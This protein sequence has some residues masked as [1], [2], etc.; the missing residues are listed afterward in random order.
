MPK[1]PKAPLSALFAINKPTGTPSMT[2][3]NRLQPL[4]AASAI[5]RD[6]DADA[7][8]DKGNQRGGGRR[9]RGRRGAPKVKMGQGGTLDP[10]ADGVLV[11]GTNAA[12]KHLSRFLDCTKEYRAI[13]LLGCS[14]DSYDSEGKRVRTVPGA[15]ALSRADVEAVLDRFRGEIVQTPPIFSALKMDGKPLYEYARTNT[16][17][18]RPI[19]P[20]TVTVHSLELLRFVPGDEHAYEY[21]AE[22]LDEAAKSELERLEKMV[23]EGRTEVPSEEEVAAASSAPAE[24]APTAESAPAASASTSTATSTS[25]SASPAPAP[26]RAP[27][28]EIRLTVS[29]GTYIRSIVHDIGAALGS[30]AHVVKLTRTRQGEFA[31][32]PPP[33][34]GVDEEGEGEGK[35]GAGCIEWALLERAIAAQERASK[36][37]K[38]GAAAGEGGPDA[39]AEG[40]RDADGWLE[41]ERELLAK[42]KE[43]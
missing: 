36:K 2:L 43:V 40:E 39:A 38:E 18:P 26:A 21:P 8:K 10:L 42:C 29:S 5:F 20:R 3:L 25:S 30:A 11:V 9:G 27:I 15:H 41:W 1:A 4:F 33:P 19:P 32:E 16:P 17:L 24:P 12:T 31:L 14:T 13:G 35:G 37:K 6:P 23:K 34:A 28:F 7:A 22:E